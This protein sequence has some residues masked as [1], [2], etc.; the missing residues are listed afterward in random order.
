[1]LVYAFATQNAKSHDWEHPY[2]FDV[3]YDYV[4][5]ADIMNNAGMPG[6]A[7]HHTGS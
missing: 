4:M 1:M 6:M 2:T 3:N 7:W 5:H